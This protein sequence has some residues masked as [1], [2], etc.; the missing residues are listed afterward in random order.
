[1]KDKLFNWLYKIAI[2]VIIHNI[3]NDKERLTPEYLESKGWTFDNGFW[4]ETGMK[5]RDMIWV[6]FEN[7]YYRVWHGKNKTFIALETS[8][9][10]FELYW[11]MSHPH[12]RTTY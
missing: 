8:K 3:V 11:L 10:W 4:Y 9:K 2:S 5:D 1:M 12:N 6:S 7:H